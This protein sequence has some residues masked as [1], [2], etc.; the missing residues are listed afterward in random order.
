M[1][2]ILWAAVLVLLAALVVLQ[3]RGVRALREWGVTPSR[4]AYLL[5][6]L[7]MVAVLVLV[8]FAFLIWSR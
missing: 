5:R 3:V 8:V 7:N 2:W 4:S 6:A 1:S